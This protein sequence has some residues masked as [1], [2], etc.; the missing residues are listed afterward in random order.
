MLR[1]IRLPL[2]FRCLRQ[3]RRL[4]QYC[5]L[6]EAFGAF[7]IEAPRDAAGVAASWLLFCDDDD[8]WHS[9]RARLAH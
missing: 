6:R 9:H 1:T 4:S 8:L 3:R 5:H 2:R 7:E